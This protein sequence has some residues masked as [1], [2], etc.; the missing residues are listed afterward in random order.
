MLILQWGDFIES[1]D[2]WLFLKS[3]QFC[4]TML[5][6]LLEVYESE[7][8]VAASLGKDV[9]SLVL[10]GAHVGRFTHF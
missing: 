1:L 10:P 5:T 2:F 6:T 3:Q 8:M 9:C 4:S 7:W